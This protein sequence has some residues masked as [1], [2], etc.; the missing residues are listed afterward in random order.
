MY[1]IRDNG[2]GAPPQANK[3]T[4]ATTYERKESGWL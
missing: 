3:H 1:N 2:D 4:H